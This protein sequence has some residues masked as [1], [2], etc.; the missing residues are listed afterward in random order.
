MSRRLDRGEPAAANH[1]FPD[2]TIRFILNGAAVGAEDVVVPN[3]PLLVAVTAT[4]IV[5]VINCPSSDN[6]P[7]IEYVLT[8]A[9]PSK[10]IF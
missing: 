4:V 1:F 2:S 3:S 10:D 8:V 6:V 5:P 7:S 9:M